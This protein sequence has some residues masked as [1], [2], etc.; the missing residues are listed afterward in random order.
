MQEILNQLKQKYG[1]GPLVMIDNGW[2]LL[3]T[4]PLPPANELVKVV[5]DICNIRSI[6]IENNRLRHS[7]NCTDTEHNFPKQ[8]RAVLLQAMDRLTPQTFSLAIHPARPNFPE[9][10]PHVIAIDPL[11]N[12]NLYPDHP[13]IH[14]WYVKLGPQGFYSEPDTLCW[15]FPSTLPKDPFGRMENLL[16]QVLMWLFRHQVWLA[17]REVK[18]PGIW[19]GPGSAPMDHSE[20]PVF[21]N[22]FAT[23]RCGSDK[24]YIDCHM[25]GDVALRE[26]CSKK[27]AKIRLAKYQ[28]RWPNFVKVPQE[29]R[30]SKLKK[31]LL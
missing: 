16:A 17:T 30:I 12:Y 5:S 21:L 23:C 6:R 29:A 18:K 27:D 10:P 7:P 2:F 20:Y 3:E 31:L 9:T 22:P 13:H 26:R 8:N 4:T 28:V 19:I 1:Y 14:C 15:G 24:H 25:V 11:I